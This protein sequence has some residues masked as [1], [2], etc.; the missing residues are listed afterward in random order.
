[1]V[2]LWSV[3][4]CGRSQVTIFDPLTSPWTAGR[5]LGASGRLEAL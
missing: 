1:M 5:R 2:V 3:S 4:R